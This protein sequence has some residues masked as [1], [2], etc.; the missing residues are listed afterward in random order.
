[1]NKRRC[2]VETERL[3]RFILDKDQ[4]ESRSQ[5]LSYLV[6]GLDEGALSLEVKIF[7]ALSDTNRLKIIKL[8]KEGELCACELTVALSNSQSTVSHHLS[9]LKSAGMIKERK[10]GKWSY[11]RL[12]DGAIIELLNQAQ[13]L[14]DR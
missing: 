1:M 7:K 8:L 4:F 6:N 10:E 14:T 3:K 13:L 11:F 5:K 12:S 9:V 2:E